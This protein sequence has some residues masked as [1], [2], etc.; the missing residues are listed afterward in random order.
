MRKVRKTRHSDIFRCVLYW[1]KETTLWKTL[2]DFRNWV[3][4][5]FSFHVSLTH[6]CVSFFSPFLLVE[7]FRDFLLIFVI[8]VTILMITL[9]ME[10]ILRFWRLFLNAKKVFFRDKFQFSWYENKWE[11]HVTFIFILNE[12]KKKIKS[13][14]I[15]I[16]FWELRELR[17]NVDFLSHEKFPINFHSSRNFHL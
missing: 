7:K 15:F 5:L 8:P 2:S 6:F 10:N 4:K 3:L 12:K 9:E 13:E 14:K 1:E 17:E 11:N 16:F